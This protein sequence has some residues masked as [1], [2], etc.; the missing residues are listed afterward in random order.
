M[1]AAAKHERFLRLREVKDRTTLSTSE[2][3]RRMER[4]DFPR[5]VRLGPQRVAWP[6]SQIDSWIAGHL[7]GETQASDD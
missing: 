6:E 5:Q 4:G 1:S 3:Y 7:P 2:I